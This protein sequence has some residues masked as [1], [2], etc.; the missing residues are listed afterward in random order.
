MVG[1]MSYLKNPEKVKGGQREVVT[2]DDN[3]QELLENI[4]KELKK[5]NLYLTLM[6]DEFITNEEI[7]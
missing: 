2:S 1:N 7:D 6:T 3:T 5:M 4:L